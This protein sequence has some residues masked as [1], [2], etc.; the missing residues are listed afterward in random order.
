MTR[1]P[2]RVYRSRASINQEAHDVV[3]EGTRDRCPGNT[4]ILD[5]VQRREFGACRSKLL[6]SFVEGRQKAVGSSE[7]RDALRVRPHKQ[8]RLVKTNQRINFR[9][10]ALAEQRQKSLRASAIAGAKCPLGFFE[11]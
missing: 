1:L 3:A 11:F 8:Q 6:D 10:S 5:V 2:I 4:G 7:S 9:K